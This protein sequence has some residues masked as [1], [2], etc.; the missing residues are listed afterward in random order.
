MD[1]MTTLTSPGLL[2]AELNLKP[3]SSN[4][5]FWFFPLYHTINSLDF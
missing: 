1:E 5:K 2:G 3:R 4:S